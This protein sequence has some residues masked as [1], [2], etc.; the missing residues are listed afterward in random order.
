[1]TGPNKTSLTGIVLIGRNE[2][3]RLKRCL[4]SIDLTSYPTVYVDSGST[5][6]SVAFCYKLGVSIVELDMK[7]PFTA[8][9]AR[10]SG[11][12]H[13]LATHPELEFI[14]FV[15][16]DCTIEQQ[17]LTAAQNYLHTNKTFAAVCGRRRELYPEDSFYNLLCD[18][19]WNTPIGET[20]ACGGD[21][22]MRVSAYNEAD[23]YRDD[24]IA[25]EEPE[26]CF[27]LR[28]QG[29]K[30]ARIDEAM[31]LHD[32]NILHFRQWWKRSKRAGYAYTKGAI[33]HGNSAER[34][35][36]RPVMR[37]LF[38]GFLLP[39]IAILSAQYATFFYWLLALYP[40]QWYRISTKERNHPSVNRRRALYL[41]LGKFAEFLGLAECLIDTLLTRHAA[42]IEYK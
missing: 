19:E 37:I 33:L 28:K 27:R 8:A 9:R 18:I 3:D 16:G 14:Q 7:I 13:L 39:L 22:L 11:A 25:G 1:M 34:L 35:N 6:D 15:D 31:T 38:W 29:W 5:D 36:I 21:V 24:L 30:I 20:K 4:N 41:M 40:L 12:Q 23:G 42:I 32:A 2:G 26:L 17:W 10:N